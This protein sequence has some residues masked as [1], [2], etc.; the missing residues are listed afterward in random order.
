MPT[1]KKSTKPDSQIIDDPDLCALEMEEFEHHLLERSTKLSAKQKRRLHKMRQQEQELSNGMQEEDAGDVD[2][3]AAKKRKTDDDSDDENLEIDESVSGPLIKFVKGG[4]LGK[5]K[6]TKAKKILGEQWTEE[7]T[8]GDIQL[9]K[10]GSSSEDEEAENVNPFAN[11]TKKPV[12][13]KEARKI[14][15]RHSLP[16]T[17]SA[18][19]KPLSKSQNGAFSIADE[20]SEPMKDGETEYFVP[21]RKLKLKEVNQSEEIVGIDHSP[22][23]NKKP[24][25]LKNPFAMQATTPQNK[26]LA[27]TLL[28][29]TP[30]SAEKRVKIM[31]NKNISQ[32]RAEYI[33]QLKSS[34]QIPFD[35]TK[36]PSK[37]LLK[38]NSVPSPINPFYRKKMRATLNDTL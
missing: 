26:L 22:P 13:N 9:S 6:G 15:K 35:P 4:T 14:N 28:P 29:A 12:E 7:E 20:W 21:S 1:I 17:T 16:A 19:P 24:K 32:N 11:K 36:K 30:S 3:V 2:E 8:N 34:P 23:S 38:P 27:K 18:K 10:E 25:L 5:V 33:Q 31:L 37:G